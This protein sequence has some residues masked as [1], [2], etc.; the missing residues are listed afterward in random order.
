M[1]DDPLQSM[2]LMYSVHGQPSLRVRFEELVL[3]H[4]RYIK[5]KMFPGL[6][7][8][9]KQPAIF[10]NMMLVA[11]ARHAKRERENSGGSFSWLLALDLHEVKL[12]NSIA[13][14]LAGQEL[15]VVLIRVDRGVYTYRFTSMFAPE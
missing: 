10:A 2:N 4:H 14:A 5:L 6:D 3:Q 8:F 11:D 9:T 7:E 12:L 15:M 13:S 1:T